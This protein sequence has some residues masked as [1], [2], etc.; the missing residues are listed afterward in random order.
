MSTALTTLKIAV[1]AAIP[2]ARVAIAIT[3]NVGAA[4]SNLMEYLRSDSIAIE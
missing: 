2:S 1:L 4:L 3:E